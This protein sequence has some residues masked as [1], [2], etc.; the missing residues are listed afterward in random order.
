MV[1]GV[2]IYDGPSGINRNKLIY[3]IWAAMIKR[4][5]SEDYLSRNPSYIGTE[6]CDEWKYYSNF[7]EWFKQNY[8]DGYQLDKDIIAGDMKLYSPATCAFVP[9]FI[10]TA[11]LTN[12]ISSEYPLGVSYKKHKK[13]VF[14]KPYVSQIKKF[15]K[16][17]SL[18]MYSTPEEAH[19]AWQL[20][21]IK[22]FQELIE[23]F[24]YLDDKILNGIQRRIFLLEDDIKNN[25]ITKILNK[26]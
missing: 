22:Y 7:E 1:S 25:R 18:G 2:G 4:C 23:R 12:R 17:K 9:S 5:Y 19:R 11:I 10:N 14:A 13:F 24:S 6:V 3:N 15:G 8:N 21:K 26:V 20:E 16:V